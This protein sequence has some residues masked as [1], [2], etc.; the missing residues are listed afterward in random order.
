MLARLQLLLLAA[1]VLAGLLQ[2]GMGLARLG[3]RGRRNG[4]GWRT[5]LTRWPNMKPRWLA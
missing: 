1:T 5:G 2:I 3:G 4:N